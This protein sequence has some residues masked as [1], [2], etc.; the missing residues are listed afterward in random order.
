MPPRSVLLSASAS[1]NISLAMNWSPRLVASLSAACSSDTSSRPGCTG[2][3]PPCTCGNALIAVSIA[4]RRAAVLAPARSSSAFGPSACASI[5]A[6]RCAGSMYG[7]SRPT[8]RLWASARACW[9]AV[10]NLSRRMDSSGLQGRWGSRPAFQG[11]EPRRQASLR[12]IERTCRWLQRLA[13]AAI[14]AG[15]EQQRRPRIRA[16][17]DHL[18]DEQHVVAVALGAVPAALEHGERPRQHRAAVA[19]GVPAAV[20]EALAMRRG[21]PARQLQ[22]RLTQHVDRKVLRGLEGGQA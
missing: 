11:G 22:V 7:L 16:V 5:A 4:I 8:A 2:W 9:N 10:V 12:P 15:V 18:A 6:S 20:L 14:A 19:P 1:R 21:E 3:P 13:D 17:M